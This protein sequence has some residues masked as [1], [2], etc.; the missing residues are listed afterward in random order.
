MDD[1]VQVNVIGMLIETVIVSALDVVVMGFY[2]YL[3]ILFKL[4]AKASD[5]SDYEL[6]SNS[7]WLIFIAQ[8]I[9]FLYYLVKAFLLT[10]DRFN[11]YFADIPYYICIFLAVNLFVKFAKR[12]IHKSV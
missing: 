12:R 9:P 1:E 11:L 10:G 8:F 6:V 2:V 4:V 7:F 3:A 5:D